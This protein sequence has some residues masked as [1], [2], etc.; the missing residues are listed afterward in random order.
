[1][2]D[3]KYKFVDERAVF[4]YG[5]SLNPQTLGSAAIDLRVMGSYMT[6]EDGKIDINNY[7]PLED[8]GVISILPGEKVF[9]GT[10]LSVFINNPNYAG[11]IVPRSSASYTNIGLANTM[12]L[13]DSDYQGTLITCIKN[14]GNAPLNIEY[15]ERVCQFYIAPIARINYV[16]TEDFEESGRSNKGFGSTGHK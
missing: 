11:F 1:M 13:I 6:S 2:L 8:D 16:L 3:V 10:G 12:G 7:I 15:K 9:F 4:A 14:L 5:D